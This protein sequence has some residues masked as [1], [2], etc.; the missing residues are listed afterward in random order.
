[1]GTLWVQRVAVNRRR[2]VRAADLVRIDRDDHDK[3]NKRSAFG[4]SGL[5]REEVEHPLD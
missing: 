4:P 2:H 1:M 3:G 5:G